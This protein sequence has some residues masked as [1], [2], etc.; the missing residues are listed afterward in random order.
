ML[1]KTEEGVF[2]KNIDLKKDEK[3]ISISVEDTVVIKNFFNE[4][5]LG[6]FDRETYSLVNTNIRLR[7]GV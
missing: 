2:K 7:Q 4:E 5:F 6:V 3:F 1:V